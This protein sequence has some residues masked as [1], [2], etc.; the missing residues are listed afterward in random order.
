MF[1]VRVSQS[2]MASLDEKKDCILA[3]E[4][5]L[6]VTVAS[7]VIDKPKLSIWMILIPVVFIYYFYR[8]QRYSSGRREFAEHFM[9]SRVRAMDEAFSAVK[10]G[11]RPDALKLCR[12]STVPS[13]IYSEYKDW[14]TVLIDH[15]MD[16]LQAEGDQIEDL[17]KSVYKSRTNYL[18]FFNRLNSVE[19][20]FN[21][22][23]KPHLPDSIDG[24][25][26]I[27]TA[28]ETCSTEWR[29]NQVESIFSGKA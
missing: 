22:A 17:I 20:K 9:I 8:L 21:S 2:A 10:S 23:L 6:A 25:N 12:M 3:Q 16:L 27:V 28:M 7:Q 5:K 13:Q 4:R 11:K 19:K 26:S 24:A 14:L 1:S 29:R 15:Y 18:L